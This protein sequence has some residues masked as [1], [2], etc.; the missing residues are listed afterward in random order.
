MLEKFEKIV[1]PDKPG[2]RNDP[3]FLAITFGACLH[4]IAPQFYPHEGAIFWTM[5][6]ANIPIMI[7][8][9]ALGMRMR[10]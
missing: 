9:A 2:L 5:V 3:A 7:G 10:R 4:V 8:G 1:H 6:L